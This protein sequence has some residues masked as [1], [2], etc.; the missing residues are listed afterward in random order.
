LVGLHKRMRAVGGKLTLLNVQ[1]P[2]YDVL[3][4]TRLTSLMDVQRQ[5]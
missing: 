5:K 4:V 1:P 2:V 3:E